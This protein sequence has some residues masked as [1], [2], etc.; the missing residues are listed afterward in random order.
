MLFA[1][2]IYLFVLSIGGIVLYGVWQAVAAGGHPTPAGRRRR[3]RL[4][5]IGDAVA[6]A[7]RL[8]QRVHR[9]DWHRGDQQRGRRVS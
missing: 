2:P 8:R 7:A 3:C 6:L 4:P 9:D 1:L 5:P